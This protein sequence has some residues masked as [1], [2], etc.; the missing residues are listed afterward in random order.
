MQKNIPLQA[1]VLRSSLDCGP[2][3]YDLCDKL[4]QVEISRKL[5]KNIC[6]LR[7]EPFELLTSLLP[8][9][10][11]LEHERRPRG[12]EKLHTDR[13]VTL[14]KDRHVYSLLQEEVFLQLPHS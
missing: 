6:A 11:Q 5:Q 13:H 1:S 14:Q 7:D 4:Y 10:G 3:L 9:S 12:A 2:V 8:P